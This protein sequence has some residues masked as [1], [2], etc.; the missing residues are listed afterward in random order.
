V[1]RDRLREAVL[2]EPELREAIIAAVEPLERVAQ[3]HALDAVHLADER[4]ERG[5]LERARL[6]GPSGARAARSTTRPRLRPGS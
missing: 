6:Q 1:R 4:L 3:P 2:L 5:I